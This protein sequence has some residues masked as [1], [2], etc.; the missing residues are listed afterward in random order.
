MEPNKMLKKYFGLNSFK[1]E[2]TA[3]IREILNGRDVLGILPTGYGKSLCYQVPA[4]MLK[5]PTLVISPLI[6]L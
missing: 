4:M 6:S 5:G 3:I 1:K 2:Q